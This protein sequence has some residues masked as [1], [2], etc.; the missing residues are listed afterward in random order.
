MARRIQEFVP[1]FDLAYWRVI[2]VFVRAAVSEAEPNTPYKAGQLLTILSRHVLWCWQTAGL[3]LEREIVFSRDVIS[4]YIEH[5]CGALTPTS[6]GTM[7]SRLLRVSEALLPRELAPRRLPPLPK[8]ES[9]TP[10]SESELVAFR[11]WANGQATAARRRDALTL[12]A[13]S[14]GAGLSAVEI[15]D[16]RAEHVH[17]DALGVLVAVSGERPRLVPVLRQ[18][19]SAL[20]EAAGERRPES[21]MFRLSRSYNHRNLVTNFLTKCNGS[22]PRPQTQRLRATWIVTHLAASTPVVP[23]M[24]ASGVQSLEALTRYLRHVPNI[25]PTRARRSMRE[26]LDQASR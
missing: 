16:V 17:A 23:F 7:R 5:G 21:P 3:P 10:Y 26:A 20:V 2:E 6:R 24:A 13:L 19:E 9:L 12:L 11:S 18:W 8:S 22:G 4:E 25:D 15:G 1:D 14:A